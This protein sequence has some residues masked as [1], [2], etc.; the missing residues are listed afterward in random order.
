MRTL[1]A[2]QFPTD[3]SARPSFADGSGSIDPL[4]RIACISL[5]FAALP[6]L[7]LLLG[8][9][10]AFNLAFAST[11]SLC[12]IFIAYFTSARSIRIDGPTGVIHAIFLMTTV[13]LFCVSSL[14][15]TFLDATLTY[16]TR[17]GEVLYLLDPVRL[18]AVVLA[19]VSAYSLATFLSVQHV[20]PNVFQ[21]RLREHLPIAFLPVTL[22]SN[23]LY[24]FKYWVHLPPI[25]EYAANASMIYVAPW[26]LIL[27]LKWT[28]LSIR[29]KVVVLACLSLAGIANLIA[30][31][32]GP[33]V[34]PFL[35]LF[36]GYLLCP[37]VKRSRKVAFLF[38]SVCVLPIIFVIGNQSRFV[39]G[40][41]GDEVTYEERLE[42][43]KSTLGQGNLVTQN[44]AIVD[45]AGRLYPQGAN[46]IVATTPELHEFQEF[47]LNVFVRE[48]IATVLPRNVPGGRTFTA[49]YVGSQ[50]LIEYGFYISS[51]NSVEVTTIAALYR[52]GGV[53]PVVIGA[54]IVSLLHRTAIH[55]IN[56]VMQWSSLGLFL[57]AGAVGSCL[58]ASNLDAISLANTFVWSL[59]VSA[60]L[61]LALKA[62]DPPA[63]TSHSEFSS[64]R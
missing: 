41:V 47:D 13:I 64:G 36:T 63:A 9:G 27:G 15:L 52:M 43:V 60:A 14:L 2:S 28:M 56:K 55:L 49:D 31:A 48:A 4:I 54:L 5:A 20:T 61:Y 8:S 21:F 51:K 11:M 33:A 17:L 58:R 30:N 10:D 37:W 53:I 25:L 12:S 62:V 34:Y 40:P 22:A 57:I 24:V 59:L 29:I 1:G 6:I 16:D 3:I 23:L 26:V 46:L 7:V 45:L 50:Q 42:A 44:G 39:L 38:A 18:Q 19:F 35:F 32:R